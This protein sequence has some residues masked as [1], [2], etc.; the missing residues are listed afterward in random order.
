MYNAETNVSVKSSAHQ[1]KTDKELQQAINEI[2]ARIE[3]D[4]PVSLAEFV[5]LTHFERG[6]YP[7]LP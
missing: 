1:F 4:E 2:K 3:K 6:I 7:R 5:M